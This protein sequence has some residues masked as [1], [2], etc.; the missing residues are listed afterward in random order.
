MP[1]HSPVYPS[2]IVADTFSFVFV[3][4]TFYGIGIHYQFT[5][6][7]NVLMGFNANSAYV[8]AR[9]NHKRTRSFLHGVSV[10]ATNNWN[11][12]K[13]FFFILMSQEWVSFFFYHF[14]NALI[15]HLESFKGFFMSIM[16]E[17]QCLVRRPSSLLFIFVGVIA[18]KR[19][20]EWSF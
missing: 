10:G 15:I 6:N 5:W 9:L 17:Y 13:V 3:G 14:Q 1:L 12:L 18:L 8:T 16:V 2:L 11:R 19:F 20:F 7:A 4:F